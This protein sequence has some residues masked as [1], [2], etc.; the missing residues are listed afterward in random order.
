MKTIKLACATVL[1]LLAVVALASPS[2]SQA[3]STVLCSFPPG[4][5]DIEFLSLFDFHVIELPEACDKIDAVEHVHETTL[6]EHPA[7]LLS[8][9]LEVKC[10]VLFLGDTLVVLASPL[11]IHGTFTYS[12]CNN[13]CTATE[14]NGPAEIKVLRE[15]TELAKVTGEGL[16]HLVC[17]A[18]INCRY[19]SV[20]LKGHGLGALTAEKEGG[21]PEWN[22]SVTLS[23]QEV[24]KES[25]SLC[26]S[27]AKLDITTTPL[28]AIYIGR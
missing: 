11:I 13:N 28:E 21:S 6:E 4:V 27:K 12:N 10:D 25:G 22:G 7:L 14:E 9:A 24:A 15:G 1:A 2:S 23:A 18:F 3:E 17:G 8:S 20:G 19:N 5:L 16:V 26:P